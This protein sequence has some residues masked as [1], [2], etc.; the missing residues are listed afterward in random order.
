MFGTKRYVPDK[1]QVVTFVSKIKGAMSPGELAKKTKCFVSQNASN[2][3]C[4]IDRE[5]FLLVA[6]WRLLLISSDDI[7]HFYINFGC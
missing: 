1:I 4:Q 6:R 5:K 2:C 7:R 3:I